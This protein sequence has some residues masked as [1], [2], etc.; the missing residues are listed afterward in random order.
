MNYRVITFS[1][2]EHYIRKFLELPGRLYTKKEIMQQPEE[3]EKILRG[4][5]ILSH[6]FTACPLLVLD[7]SDTPTGRAVLTFYPDD[8]DAFL[9]FFECENKDKPASLLLGKA[10]EIAKNKGCTRIVGPIDASF[11]IRYRFKANCFDRSYTGEPYNKDYYIA[12]WRKAGYEIAEHYY[13]NHYRKVGKDHLNPLFSSRLAQKLE[14]GYRIESPSRDTFESA[15]DEVY[16]LLIELYQSFPAYKRITREE[17]VS[18]YSYL[19]LLISYPMVKMAYYEDRPVGFFVSIPDYG[20]TVYGK[21]SLFDYIRILKTRTKP[22]SYVMLYMGIDGSHHGL[23]KA[24]AQAIKQELQR[25]GTPSVGALIR[26]GNI[27][28][29]YFQELIDCEYEYVLLSR[30]LT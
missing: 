15:L 17:F 12:L 2:Q 4:T 6:Y 8:T 3:E 26:Q 9:G 14:E 20:N 24:M 1:T 10:E 22:K 11:W 7:E 5:H 18:L 29:D 13:S 21:L 19:K 27:N 30:P 16:A 25:L 23:G 28:R